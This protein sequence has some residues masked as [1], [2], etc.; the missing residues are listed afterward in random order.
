V[1]LSTRTLLFTDIEGSTPLLE[2]AGAQYP[3]LLNEHRRI[4]RGAVQRAGGTEHGTEGD[5]FFVTFDSPTAALAAVVEAQLGLE[6]HPWPDGLRVRVRMGLHIGEVLEHDG[7]LVGM[8]IHHA[9]RIGAAAH[10]G[11]IVVSDAVSAMVRT[12]PDGTELRTLG[13]H[14]LRDVGDIELFQVDHPTLQRDFPQPR[15]VQ[16]QR[17]NLPRMTTAFVGGDQLMATIEEQQRTAA[18]VTLTGTGGVGKTRAAV[19]FAT[20]QMPRFPN[21]VYFVDLS[22]IAESDA[23][24]GAVTAVLPVI[25]LGERSAIE[26]LIE[27][28]AD[29]TMLLVIDNCEHVVADVHDVVDSLLQACPNNDRTRHTARSDPLDP[30][31]PVDPFDPFDPPVNVGSSPL[32]FCSE[33]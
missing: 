28:I 24:A 19:E 13:H 16:T 22:S 11:Q 23:V 2:R 32:E 25:T 4:V 12:L 7:D 5:S 31:D 21:G 29:R 17:T 6:Q 18:L 30:L 9:A 10:G 3:S 1:T 20:R 8:A 27:W 26:N 15:G 14:R 33:M